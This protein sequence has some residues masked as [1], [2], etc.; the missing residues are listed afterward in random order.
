MFYHI[1]PRYIGIQKGLNYFQ[2][3]SCHSKKPIWACVCFRSQNMMHLV[4]TFLFVFY[5]NPQNYQLWVSI[6]QICIQFLLFLRKESITSSS[7]QKAGVAKAIFFDCSMSTKPLARTRS[8]Q[9]GM[10]K[11]SPYVLCH[12]WSIQGLIYDLM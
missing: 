3:L 10:R 2:W 9:L 12:S 4:N 8:L 11:W 5:S 1:L 7:L 6:C